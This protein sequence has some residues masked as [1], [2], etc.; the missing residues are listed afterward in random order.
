MTCAKREVACSIHTV[1]GHVAYGSNRV[2]NPQPTCPRLEG[3]G[4]EKCHTICRQPAHAEVAALVNAAERGLDV[5]GGSAVIHGHYMVC[6]DCR[7]RLFA[8]GV[9]IIIYEP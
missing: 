1:D 4:Y 3:E 6:D 8:A 2:L 5:Y 9:T 7:R